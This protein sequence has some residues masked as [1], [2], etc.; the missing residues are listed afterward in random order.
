[1]S[2]VN[3]LAGVRKKRNENICGILPTHTYMAQKCAGTHR[4]GPGKRHFLSEGARR[5]LR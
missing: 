2:D 5:P 3:G 4:R 1:V